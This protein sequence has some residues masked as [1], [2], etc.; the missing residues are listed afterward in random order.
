M[1]AVRD[2]NV[3]DER[4]LISDFGDC[5]YQPLFG[6]YSSLIPI[7]IECELAALPKMEGSGSPEKDLT[8]TAFL[9]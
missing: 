9:F 2:A 4:N 5:G 1:I 7:Y 8:P 3:R 6:P